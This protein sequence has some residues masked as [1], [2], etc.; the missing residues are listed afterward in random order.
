MI[1][2]REKS[3]LEERWKKTCLHVSGF[4]QRGTVMLEFSIH[5]HIVSL[6]PYCMSQHAV[7][8]DAF[9][10]CTS[11][12]LNF[13]CDFGWRSQHPCCGTSALI[14]TAPYWNVY[15]FHNIFNNCFNNAWWCYKKDKTT[16]NS[17]QAVA[18]HIAP[19]SI[20]VYTFC[21]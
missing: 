15:D 12:E 16:K 4:L 8:K 11:W 5:V 1:K 3:L 20:D 19:L 14:C 18:Q 10:M 9:F 2:E 6:K 17:L 21:R 13:R 7:I